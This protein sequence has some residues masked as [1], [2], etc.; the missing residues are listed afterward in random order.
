MIFCSHD[1]SFSW[2]SV[3]M[4]FRSR[5]FLLVWFSV[6]REDFWRWSLGSSSQLRVSPV[7]LESGC[8][9]LKG[10]YWRLSSGTF[11]P[12]FNPVLVK[13][14]F[15]LEKSFRAGAWSGEQPGHRGRWG[16]ALCWGGVQ[17]WEVFQH[18]LHVQGEE[19]PSRLYFPDWENYLRNFPG[20]Q[21]GDCH[22]VPARAFP[23]LLRGV[24]GDWKVRSPNLRIRTRKTPEKYQTLSTTFLKVTMKSWSC[25][26]EQ[27]V[28]TRVHIDQSV[29]ALFLSVLGPIWCPSPSVL[30]CHGLVT[31]CPVLGPVWCLDT[32]LVSSWQTVL[33]LYG[34]VMARLGPA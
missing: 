13:F 25:Q 34:Q 28:L 10:D 24:W 3:L 29:R 23:G 11:G 19:T 9:E 15:R 30:L 20:R 18:D 7:H 26:A 33:I 27:K 16:D 1:F 2:F 8:K 6:W 22:Q 21:D 31:R 12:S 5:D 17:P 14:V 4:I 32:S